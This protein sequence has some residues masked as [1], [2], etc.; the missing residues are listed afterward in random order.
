MYATS[1][2]RYSGGRCAR[3]RHEEGAEKEGDLGVHDQAREKG[4]GLHQERLN[5]KPISGV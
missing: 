1:I 5:C 2:D 3:Q 4:E